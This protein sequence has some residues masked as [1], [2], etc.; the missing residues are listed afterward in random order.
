LFEF[1][2]DG[3][4]GDDERAPL[5]PSDMVAKLRSPPGIIF[6]G[7]PPTIARLGSTL[8][9]PGSDRRVPPPDD[10]M[11]GSPFPPPA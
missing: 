11:E 1:E 6:I 9:P 3:D 5:P 8:P 2:C 4:D 7:T 10:A